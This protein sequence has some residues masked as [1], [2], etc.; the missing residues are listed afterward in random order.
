MRIVMLG[1]GDDPNQLSASLSRGLA[2][3]DC[4][5]SLFE[6][7]PSSKSFGR[8][9]VRHVM[10]RF[11]FP[12]FNKR[13]CREITAVRP[14]VFWL[15]KGMEVYPRTLDKLRTLGVTLVNYNAD[16]P[17]R[18]FSRGSG[19]SNVLRSIPK[20]DLHL[21]YSRAI[22]REMQERYPNLRIGVVPF[23]HDVDDAIY[24]RI[25]SEDEVQRVCFLGNPD[26]HRAREITVLVEAGLPVDVYGHR[27]DD[28]LA[29]ATNLRI[30]GQAVGGELYRTLR[31]YR[32]QMNFF[33]P[34]NVASHNMRTFEVPACGAIMLAE[35][36]IEHRDFFESGREAFYFGSRLEMVEGARVLLAMPKVE[37][38][39]VRRAARRRSV[40]SGYWYRDRA[41]ESLAL[42]ESAHALRSARN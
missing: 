20:Y 7:E 10:P 21:T 32:V 8:R 9:L 19:N 15:F 41:I 36:S 4:A 28:F 3:L 16:H 35:D 1:G 27:W 40:N 39:A 13:I 2:D 17:L 42:I 5:L 31:L 12:E 38:D 25:E 14:D 11:G 24:N 23:G 18:Y 33:R 26:D 22:A 29:P 6:I 37:A 30:H 34:H